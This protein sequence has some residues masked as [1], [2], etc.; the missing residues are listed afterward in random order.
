MPDTFRWYRWNRQ[1]DKHN[2]GGQ[3]VHELPVTTGEMTRK[4]ST[5]SPNDGSA[6][7]AFANPA[8]NPSPRPV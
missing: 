4:S 6:R 8:T 3:H 5:S 1:Q 2:D 7:N